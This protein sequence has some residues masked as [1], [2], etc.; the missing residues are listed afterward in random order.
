MAKKEALEA[1]EYFEQ[2]WRYTAALRNWL[3]VYGIGGC[4]LLVRERTGIFKSICKETVASIFLWFIL[5]VGAQILLVLLNKYIHW[6][7]YWGMEDKEFRDR[8]IH[9]CAR[10]VSRKIKID[11][12]IDLFTLIA[13]VYATWLMFRTLS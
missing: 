3:V 9:K 5:G 10:A 11:F 12:Y 6:C 4:V 13:F 8:D 1:K 7:V 2:Y